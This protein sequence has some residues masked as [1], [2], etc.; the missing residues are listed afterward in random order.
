MQVLGMVDGWPDAIKVIDC[1][2]L[3][4]LAALS[5]IKLIYGIYVLPEVNK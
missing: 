3:L 5:L 4:V 2:P 1:L